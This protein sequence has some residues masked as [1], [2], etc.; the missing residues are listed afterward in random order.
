MIVTTEDTGV[1]ILREFTAHLPVKSGQPAV[2]QVRVEG[3]KGIGLNSGQGSAPILQMA[4][5][6]DKGNT[7]GAFRDRSL[8]AIGEYSAR[9][10]WEQNGRAGPEQTVFWFRWSDPVGFLPSRVPVGER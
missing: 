5:S 8:G 7:F 10:S 1:Q 3:T 4:I 6:R 9:T 2:G